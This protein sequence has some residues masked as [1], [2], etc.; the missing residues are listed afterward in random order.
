MPDRIPVTPDAGLGTRTVFIMWIFILSLE[1]ISGTY[2]LLNGLVTMSLNKTIYLTLII[3]RQ[4]CLLFSPNSLRPMNVFE[5]NIH[6][7]LS[8]M[9][10]GTASYMEGFQA[11]SG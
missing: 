4:Q 11:I 5:S 7:I 3:W 9:S 8:M 6:I 2:I 1:L 10:Y